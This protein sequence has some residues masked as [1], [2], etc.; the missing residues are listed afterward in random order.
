MKQITVI[1]RKEWK[2][3]VIFSNISNEK[4]EQLK[5]DWYKI[6]YKIK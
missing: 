5:Q 6:I 4:L 1:A 3:D 2:G